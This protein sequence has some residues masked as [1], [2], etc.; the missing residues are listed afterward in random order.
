MCKKLNFLIFLC[1][2]LCLA[3]NTAKA[4][5]LDGLVV[6]HDFEDLVD[7]SGNGLDL[8]LE[9]DAE[10]ADGMLWLDGDGDWADV[11]SFADFDAVNPL[12]DE[13]GA[14]TEFTLVVAYASD[15]EEETSALVSI[16]PEVGTGTGDLSLFYEPGGLFIDHWWVGATDFMDLESGGELVWAIVTYSP[17][18]GYSFFSLEDDIVTEMVAGEE[19]DWGEAWN[20]NLDY[21]ARLGY[22]TNETVAIEEGEFWQGWFAGQIDHFAMWNRVLD[23]EEMPEVVDFGAG[24]PSGKAGNPE[25]GNGD[26]FVD[27]EAELSWNPGANAVTHNV[28]FGKDFDD[29]NEADTDSALLVSPDQTDTTYAP[30]GILDWGQEYFWRIDEINVGDPNSPWK[31]DTWSFTVEPYAYAL[32]PEE[33]QILG[34]DIA[35]SSSEEDSWPDA[36][37][38]DGLDGD[39]H[40]TEAWAMWLS[41]IDPNGAWIEYPFDKAYKLSEILIWNYNE[42]IEPVLGFGFNETVIEY[43]TDEGETFVELATVNLNQA[44]GEPT[45][46][47]DTLDLQDVVATNLRL[48]AKSNFSGGF[49]EQ[50]GLSAVRILYLPV[51][52]MDPMPEP[53]EFVELDD[54]VL[55][56]RAGREAVSHKVHLGTDEEDL[57]LVDTTDETS[58]EPEGLE[59]DTEYFWRIDET[60]ESALAGAVWSFITNAFL[61]IDDMESYEDSLDDEEIAIWG[62]WADGATEPT[63]GSLVGYDFGETEKDITHDE[64]D[65]SM[66]LTYDNTGDAVVSE[67]TRT[68]DE[69]QDWTRSEVKALT[70]YVHGSEDNVGGQ[71]YIKINGVEQAITVDLTD[72]SWQ[73]VNIDLADFTSVNLESVTSMTIGIKGAGSSGIVFIDNIRL[74]PSRCIAALSPEGDLNGD[75]IVDE[76]DLAIITDNWLSGS[77]T[78]EY[79]FDSSLQ[80]TSGNGRHGVDVGGVTVAGGVLTLDGA[81]FVDVPLGEDNPFDGS[82]DF[83]IALDFQAETPS[84][85]FSSARDD[86]P[87]NHAM[88]IFV[89]HWDEEDYAEVIYDQFYIGGAGSGDN[90]LDGEWHSVVATYSAAV[91]LIRVYLDGEPGWDGEWNPDIPDI[92]DDTVRI[93]GSLN[94]VYPYDEGVDNLIGSI[95]NLRIFSFVLT[96]DQAAG[97][98]DSI[99]THP[100]D[101]NGDGIVDQA[102]KDIVEANMGAISVWP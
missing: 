80:D 101:V 91:E 26:D 39:E 57:P 51:R 63:N 88:S 4:D 97:L 27:R 52:A 90:P 71:M 85:L 15:W 45:G 36:T 11:G 19:M 87:D 56:W 66:P 86:E 32:D 69:A 21:G 95:D 44:P 23:V 35:V 77:L 84:L 102:D 65:Q 98:P 25:P 89:H 14:P 42:D 83:S 34:D 99:P 94:S 3:G 59:L 24:P 29:V 5:L 20:L 10:I 68:Y 16:G 70:L 76:E 46:P 60:D 58:Y 93:G 50:F 100:A 53:E 28:Y 64:S 73:E 79:T 72:E 55:E 18:E 48:T 22:F 37:V 75:C 62:T 1:I 8:I 6:L 67:A 17:D 30:V 38:W 92:A 61:T 40:T 31:G 78:V 43:S 13:E 33:D 82:Q 47:T 9:G 74:Y 54:L 7:G 49:E 81:N 41:G 96:D 12:A 2:A